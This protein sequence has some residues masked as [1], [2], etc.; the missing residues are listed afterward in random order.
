LQQNYENDVCNLTHRVKAAGCA[1][2]ISASQLSDIVRALPQ[3][4]SPQLLTSIDTFEDAAVYKLSESQALVQTIDFFPPV[5]DDPYTFGVI[6]AT[7]ALSDI[8][9]MGGTPTLA[10]NVLCFPVC[11]FPLAVASR[12]MEGGAHAVKQAGALI[13]G[14]HSIQSTDLIYGLCVSGFVHPDRIL[15]NCGARD[16]DAILL[17]KAIGTGVGLLGLKGEMLR[18]EAAAQ[19]MR[20]LTQLN[21]GAATV[22]A[23]CRVHA[24]TDITGFGLI[25]HL[26]EMAKG[27]GLQA[28][29]KAD[30]VP[31]LPEVRELASQGFVPAGAYANRTSYQQD[32]SISRHVDL[33]VADLLF[34]P[35]TSGGLLLALPAEDCQSV[36]S[37]LSGLG[38]TAACIG[39]FHKGKKG[40]VEVEA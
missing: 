35:Q 27:S 17:C 37:A 36:L 3:F 9:A 1:A 26:H 16:G 14:G 23:S 39:E 29:L 22:A 24:C 18:D 4:A 28:T 11:D 13:V 8:Y 33:A 30:R 31:L 40:Q 6:A 15:I 5:V 19:L 32:V 34:D 10:L 2:K 38:Y 21:A 12:I 20:S 7:N 25:G